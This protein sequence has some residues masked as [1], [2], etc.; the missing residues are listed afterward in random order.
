MIDIKFGPLFPWHFRFLAIAVIILAFALIQNQPLISMILILGSFFTLTSYEG[1]EVNVSNKTFR[2]Y[3]AF[4]F[5]KTGAFEKY[6]EAERIFINSANLS[7]KI[8]SAHTALSTTFKERVFNAYLKF[9]DGEKVH[10]LRS[11]NRDALIKKLTP[12][13]ERLSVEI[14][15][16][17]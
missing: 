12:I 6:T 8:Y 14:V 10:L 4:F 7:Q 16:V 1:T 2:S 11:K 3:T 9:S 5:V 17:L 13:S 15:E